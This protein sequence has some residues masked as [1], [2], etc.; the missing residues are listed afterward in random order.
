[1]ITICLDS[2]IKEK[3]KRKESFPGL[4]GLRLEEKKRRRKERMCEYAQERHF[5]KQNKMN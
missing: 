5:Q 1:M 3:K 4:S 2:Y